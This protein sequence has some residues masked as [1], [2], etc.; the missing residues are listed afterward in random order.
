MLAE[1]DSKWQQCNSGS[2][3]WKTDLDSSYN[4]LLALSYLLFYSLMEADNSKV[5]FNWF[6]HM[7]LQ[8]PCHLVICIMQQFL[9]KP[10]LQISEGLLPKVVPHSKQASPLCSAIVYCI[11]QI[12]L[13]LN[14]E[15]GRM[16]RPL[17]HPESGKI[18]AKTALLLSL[19]SLDCPIVR[20]GPQMTA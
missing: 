5:R 15:L 13:L 9:G 14:C 8:G 6:L 4:L 17:A 11:I 2:K 10:L 18:R 3:C 20:G 1:P 19:S 7:L 12:S 16:K